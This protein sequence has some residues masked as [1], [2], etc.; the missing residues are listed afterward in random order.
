[1]GRPSKLTSH[2]RREAIE[3]LERGD[4]LTDIA[5]TFGVTHPTIAKL[6]PFTEGSAAVTQA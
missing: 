1:M 3:R 2:Q 4:T 5:R 6:R